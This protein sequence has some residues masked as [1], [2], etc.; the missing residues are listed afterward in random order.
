MKALSLWQPWASAMAS[1]AKQI[2]TRSWP[3]AYRGELVICAAKRK[4]T[5]AELSGLNDSVVKTLA[6]VL[7]YGA[8][9]CIVEL[10]DCWRTERVNGLRQPISDMEREFGDYSPGR[11]AWLT[12]NLRVLQ[13]PVPILGRQGLWNLSLREVIQIDKQR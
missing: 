2:E 6:E 4:P 5:R 8:A 11:W 7:P 3:T 13:S 10:Y 12:R 1:N 9:L